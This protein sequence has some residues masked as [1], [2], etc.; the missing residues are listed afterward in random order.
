MY[1][2]CTK[3]TAFFTTDYAVVVL[4]DTTVFFGNRT[5]VVEMTIEVMILFC[6]LMINCCQIFQVSPPCHEV[7][8]VNYEVKLNATYSDDRLLFISNGD[9]GKYTVTL[10]SPDI[11]TNEK[12][13]ESVA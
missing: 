3:L 4:S 10:G 1:I 11:K 2:A 7:G 6:R 13:L 8:V 9:V 5:V 12:H